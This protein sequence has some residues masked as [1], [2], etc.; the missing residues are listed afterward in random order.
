MTKAMAKILR[1][2][3]KSDFTNNPKNDYNSRN[4]LENN[5][6]EKSVKF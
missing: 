5:N 3:D 4:N 1:N 6:L 2:S